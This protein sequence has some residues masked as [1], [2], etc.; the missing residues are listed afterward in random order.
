MAVEEKN[1]QEGYIKFNLMWEKGALVDTGWFHQICWLRDRLKGLGWIGVG[2]DGIGF[3]NVSVRLKGCKDLFVI[4]GSATGGKRHLS[5]DDFAYVS[6]VDIDKNFV[7]C[8]GM[9]KASSESMSHYVVYLAGRDYVG[10]VAHI[11]SEYMWEKL[12]DVLPKTDRDAEYGTVRLAYNLLDVVKENLDKY[13]VVLLGH[14]P[15]L[16]F[17]GKDVWMLWWRMKQFM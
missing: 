13:G 17:W 11:H 9:R 3:G 6:E 2:N 4:T 16:I 5:V 8:Y 10:A 7:R 1:L 14:Y 12:R 15:G